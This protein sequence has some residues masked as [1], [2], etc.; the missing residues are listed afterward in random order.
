M[1]SSDPCFSGMTA[2][3]VALVHVGRLGHLVPWDTL[4]KHPEV[5]QGGTWRIL[6]VPSYPTL[7]LT[8]VHLLQKCWST[9]QPA[10]SPQNCPWAQSP[11][12]TPETQSPGLGLEVMIE[13]HRGASLPPGGLNFLPQ[14]ALPFFLVSSEEVN[15]STPHPCPRPPSCWGFILA[16]PCPP[17]SPLP[18]STISSQSLEPT[19]EELDLTEWFSQR[20]AEVVEASWM[21]G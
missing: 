13:V 5:R 9:T 18:D 16:Q 1:H 21:K 20:P 2:A 19:P 6:L 7:F 12:I 15:L 14:S 3:G 17:Q 4:T 8:Y 11:G 10:P